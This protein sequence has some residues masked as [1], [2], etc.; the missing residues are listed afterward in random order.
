[1]RP[2]LTTS[3]SASSIRARLSITISSGR[4]RLLVSA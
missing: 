3:S 4:I 1:M 2:R